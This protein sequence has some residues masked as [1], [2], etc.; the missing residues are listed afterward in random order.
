MATSE[1]NEN[2][3]PLLSKVAKKYLAVQATS[4]ASERVFSTAGDV[5]T[6]QRACLSGE[7]VDTLIFLKMNLPKINIT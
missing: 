6:S 7:H 4:V 5:V 2:K 3:F 1:R